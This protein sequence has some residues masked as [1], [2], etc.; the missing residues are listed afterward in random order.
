MLRVFGAK[1]GKNV[2]IYPSVIIAIPWNLKIG[3]YVAIGDGV[4]LYSLGLIDISDSVTISQRAHLCGGSH[5]YTV[6]SMPLLKLPIT[7]EKG[8]WVCAEAFVG[9]GVVIGQGSVVS[10]RCVVMRDIP[11]NVVAIGNPFILKSKRDL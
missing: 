6:S 1:I 9:P 2:H 8:V 4:N 10:A 3:C 11:E 7:I 5:D